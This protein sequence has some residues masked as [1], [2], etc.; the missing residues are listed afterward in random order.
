MKSFKLRDLMINVLPEQGKTA[1]ICASRGVVTICE[2]ASLALTECGCSR[3]T[4]TGC[5]CLTHNAVSCHPYP[6]NVCICSHVVSCTACTANPSCAGCSVVISCVHACSQIAS[7][8]AGGTRQPFTIT[9][10]TDPGPEQT[11]TTLAE[12]KDQL[13]QQLAAI[14]EQEKAVAES[15][16]PQTVVEAD[17][18]KQKLEQALEE[19]ATRRTELSKSEKAQAKEPKK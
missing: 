2:C 10:P 13:K 1:C 18:L 15:L 12:L 8:C 11:A 5:F 3:F 14:E 16:K 19:L 7:I 6:S 17:D 4:A 9:G